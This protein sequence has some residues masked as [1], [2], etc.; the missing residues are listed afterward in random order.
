MTAAQILDGFPA[1]AATR[2][3]VALAVESGL[4][5][6]PR[7]ERR[8]HGLYRI[9]V[10]AAGRDGMFGCI[11]VS[12]RTGRIV[13]AYLTAGNDAAEQRIESIAGVRQAIRA[14]TATR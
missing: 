14:W 2:Q 6:S 11:D 7:P 9:V 4:R 3:I 5:P 13:R 1:T 8:P 10:N 12:E